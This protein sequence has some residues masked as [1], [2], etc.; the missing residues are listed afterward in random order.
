MHR[1]VCYILCSVLAVTGTQA[2]SDDGPPD[3]ENSYVTDGKK[4]YDDIATLFFP[5]SVV[6]S[7]GNFNYRSANLTK[8]SW[9][10]RLMDHL[11]AF[12][13]AVCS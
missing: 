4:D 3:C 12:T 11:K 6:T 1:F 2:L 13:V 9:V 10:D 5:G 8:N 7:P